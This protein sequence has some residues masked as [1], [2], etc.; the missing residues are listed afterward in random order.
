MKQKKKW[1]AYA[2]A[3]AVSAS[4]PSMVYAAPGDATEIQKMPKD[5]VEAAKQADK[6][7]KAID[8]AEARAEEKLQE[9]KTDVKPVYQQLTTEEGK[10]EAEKPAAEDPAEAEKKA[11]AEAWAN[12]RPEES[13][14]QKEVDGLQGLT[15]V[16]IVYEGASDKTLNTT[17]AATHMKAGDKFTSKALADDRDSIYNTGYFY[18][19]YPTFEKVPEGVVIT[20]HLLENPI[21]RSVKITGNE[22]E[23]DDT[24]YG[25]MTVRT[26]TILN[27][28]ILHENIQAI[29]EQYK[30]DGYILAKVTDM[31]IDGNGDLVIKINEGKLE[32]YTVKGN[33]KTKDYVILR[34][35]RQK[36]GTPFNSKLAKRSMQ[37]V[38]NLGFFEDVNIKMN[39][40]VEPNAVVMEVDVKEK[41]TGNFGIGAGYSSSDGIIGMISIA[42]TN[43]RGVGDAISLTYSIS[44]D[45]TDAHGYTFAYRH[46]WIDKKETAGTLRVY[47]RTYEYD[48]YD[49]NGDLNETYMR[50]YSGGEITLSRPV[51]EYSTNSITLRSRNDEYVEHVDD[52]NHNRSAQ[53]IKDNFGRTNSVTLSH[54]TDTRDNI[55]NPMEGGRLEFTGEVAGLGGDFNYQKASVEDQRYFKI[56]H[57]Q[58][59]A[60]R[61]QLGA[62]F[63]DMSYF[64]K[65]RIGGQTTLRG[66]RDD[67]FRGK[68]MGLFTVEYR[69]PIIKQ[70]QGAIFTDWGAAWDDGWTPDGDAI[71]GSVGV[72][73]SLNT[74]LGPLR[75]DYGR[76]ED[77]GRV[78]FTV[79]GSF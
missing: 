1:L 18:D 52:G 16:D 7:A 26:G 65:F 57:A 17:K 55:Y 74:P 69:F 8:A 11:R 66:Y 77:G 50:K 49:E 33:E 10:T 21:L 40:G 6:S 31:N 30:K 60:L 63:G 54:V 35:M 44:G 47:N 41:H 34:E 51:S 70:V 75:L 36:V 39:P 61:G 56:G 15:V 29:Q 42:D 62:G 71:K 78:H 27:N 48:D 59:I 79:G 28:R 67:Q 73:L 32:G 24:L 25:L 13:A 68:K 45:D 2:V 72:G 4:V 19:I 76:G 14:I 20:Y 46:P 53:W 37:R 3:L 5:Q 23:T 58:V 12:S 9:Q 64:N 22:S 43:F 38:Y